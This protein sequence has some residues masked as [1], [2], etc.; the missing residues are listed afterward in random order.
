MNSPATGNNTDE[1]RFAFG[2]NW[3]RFLACLND[4]RIATA[5]E[6]IRRL[7]HCDS[8]HGRS[9]LDVG[10]GSGLFSLAARRLGARVRSFDYDTD[11]VGCCE[12]LKRRYFA[13][14]ADW[15]IERGS[16]LDRDWL[17]KLGPFDIVYSWG[18]LHHTGR[19]W[20]GIQ[21]ATELV[22]SGGQLVLSL[23]NDQGGASR[24]WRMIKRIYN[25]VPKLMQWL[26]VVAIGFWMEL[27]QFLIRLVRLQNPLPFAE[28]SRRKEE[29]GMSYWHD[30]V[31]WIGGYPFEVAKPEEVFRFV[32]SRG[33][34]LTEL[35]TQAGGYGCNEYVF[36]RI[37]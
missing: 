32:R 24:R 5:E 14:D 18:V 2:K 21:N 6:S 11:S 31:D 37:V 36:R 15:I 3:Q 26:M 27:R 13:N 1:R 29:R 25:S 4:Q 19:M 35:T 28:W 16:V 17:S 23:Y 7:L 33:F 9:F 20:D 22:A 12:E 34:E 10:C 8:L 30:L